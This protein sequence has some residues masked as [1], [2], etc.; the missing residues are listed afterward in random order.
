MITT[1]QLS[2]EEIKEA[3][4]DFMVKK[5]KIASGDPITVNFVVTPKTDMRGEPSGQDV[6]IKV[7]HNE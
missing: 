1:S 6:H 3:I 2:P 4:A 5:Q 7:T